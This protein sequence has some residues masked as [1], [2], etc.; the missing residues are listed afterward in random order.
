M[1]EVRD[2]RT[3]VKA[4]FTLCEPKTTY[5]PTSERECDVC[6]RPSPRLVSECPHAAMASYICP[7]DGP[8]RQ[9]AGGR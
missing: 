1:G 6:F 2:A 8:G 9:Y 3:A 5:E 7:V 4:H